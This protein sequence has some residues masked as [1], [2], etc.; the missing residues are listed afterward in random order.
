MTTASE[1]QVATPELDALRTFLRPLPT[2]P[3]MDEAGLTAALAAAWP[4]L[5]DS[6]E[7]AMAA[8]KVRRLE[9]PSWKP[10][11]LAF[12][13]ERHGATVL[14]SSRA[15]V[16]VWTVNV[17]AGT[18]D[19]AH[20]SHRQV[21]PSAARLTVGP[22]ADEIV[23]L[24]LSGQTDARLTWSSDKQSV[25]VNIGLV[26]PDSGPKQTITGRRKRFRQALQ[27]RLAA[28]GWDEDGYNSYSRTH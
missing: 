10:P 14:G 15:E 16:Q 23:T 4:S 5:G 9:A 20:S 17:E 12:D 25:N 13:L 27:E 19:V 7:T 6:S 1:D 11:L 24:I 28:S 21:R 18:A 2:G 8:F 22:L 26:V 3:V